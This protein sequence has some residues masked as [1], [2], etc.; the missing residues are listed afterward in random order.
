MV[1]RIV[2]LTA[3]LLLAVA[4]LASAATVR[5]YVFRQAPNGVS[6]PAPRVMLTLYSA[7]MGR[8]S[9]AYS[10]EDGFYYFYNVPPGNY[11]L[12]IYQDP[13][14]PPVMRFNVTVVPPDPQHPTT[15]IA[16]IRVG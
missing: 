14:M 13:R 11:V 1:K 9:P 16:P 5:G 6:Y 10:G 8:S 3:F 12:E 7:S 15:D 4:T 2:V